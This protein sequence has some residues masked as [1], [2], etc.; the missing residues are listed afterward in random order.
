MAYFRA[1]KQI[2]RL[3]RIVVPAPM[4]HLLSIDV[5]DVVDVR[6]VDDHIEIAKVEPRC[7]F[8]GSDTDLR[9]MHGKYA[10][11]RCLIDIGRDPDE[12]LEHESN[13]GTT[14]RPSRQHT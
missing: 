8:C 2:D 6:I 14:R 3:G 1:E 9:S 4:R 5:G 7:V 11:I 10:C 12:E 13:N